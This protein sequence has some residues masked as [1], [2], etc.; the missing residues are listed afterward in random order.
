MQ[1]EV[2]TIDY[3]PENE[4]HGHPRSLFSIWFSANMQLTTIITGAIAVEVLKLDLFWSVVAILVGNLLGGIFMAYHSAQGPILGVPQMIQSRAQFGFYGAI[5][6]LI[7]VI[8]MYVGFFASSG[9]LG[10]Q[11]L[12]HLLPLGDSVNIVIISVLA[13][14]MAIFG[15]EL[16]HQYE[17]VMSYIFALFFLVFTY[18]VLFGGLLPAG[19][20]NVGKL[21]IPGFLMGVSIFATWQIAY[22]PYV[23][24][25][26]RYL[27]ASVNMGSVF[28]YTYWGA[29]IGSAWMMI[30]GA[31]LTIIDAKANLMDLV[32]RISGSFGVIAI[33]LIVFGIL[34]INVMNL[35]GGFMSTLTTTTPFMKVKKKI[36]YSQRMVYI[37]IVAIVGT[38][39]A[40]W[41]Q[42]NFLNNYTN[43]LLLLLYFMIPWTAINLMDFYILRDGHY[44]IKSI[45]EPG[46][47]Y[48]SFNW[49][50]LGVY[51]VGFLV[52]LPFV[53]TDIYE[54]PLAKAMGGADIAW[55]VGLAVSSVLYY[56]LGRRR[57]RDPKV[58]R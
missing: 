18:R 49:V 53:N 23:A 39:L 2:H 17:K 36:T 1:V 57:T 16:I 32:Y 9:V 35:Y 30:I 58:P 21:D 52:Q 29:V 31:A 37:I 25:Y 19:V 13:V 44:D 20:W 56:L 22:A 51:V 33:I 47:Q 40:I 12:N 11:A 10:G 50:A 45:L 3:V 7:I 24:D 42:G 27:P 6:P 55:I 43:F 26:S 46:G 48:G 8:L 41:G 14:I 5:L 15:Y 34:A 28:K 54:G 38:V 4:R